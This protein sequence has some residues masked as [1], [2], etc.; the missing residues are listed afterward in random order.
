MRRSDQARVRIHVE[1]ANDNAP[2]FVG[3]DQ[4][5]A[6]VKEE[7]DEGL[8]VTQLYAQDA[9]AGENATVTYHFVASDGMNDLTSFSLDPKSGVITTKRPL[10]YEVRRSYTLTVV[11]RD[12]AR[13]KDS[14][15]SPARLVRVE[16]QDIND[17]QPIFVDHRQVCSGTTFAG[18]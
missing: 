9:D 4:F 2:V 12:S 17:N 8:L 14:L 10:D 1:D 11:A 16:V 6:L 3:D 13:G 7:Q 18:K 5:L 15:E